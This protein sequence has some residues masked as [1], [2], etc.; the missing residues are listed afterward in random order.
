MK[1]IMFKSKF[2][3][4]KTPLETLE[5]KTIQLQITVKAID[6]LTVTKT[7]RTLVHTLPHTH[8]HTHMSSPKIYLICHRQLRKH[9]MRISYASAKSNEKKEARKIFGI[10]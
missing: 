5:N 2:I 8:T 4:E 10:K 6:N 3:I 9:K 7:I 1:I